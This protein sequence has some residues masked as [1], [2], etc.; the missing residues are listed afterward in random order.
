MQFFVILVIG[1]L[2][3]AAGMFIMFS[4]QVFLAIRETAINTRKEDAVSTSNYNVLL[5]AAKLNYFIGGA[6][7]VT[8]WVSGF[9]L[10]Y[11]IG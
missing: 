5:I 9:G 8:G 6:V 1:I 10:V 3:T 4:G 2:F 11:V 7:I